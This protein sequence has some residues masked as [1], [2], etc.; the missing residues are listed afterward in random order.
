MSSQRNV[1]DQVGGRMWAE[2]LWIENSSHQHS[3]E[4]KYCHR[5]SGGWEEVAERVTVYGHSDHLR[6][7]VSCASSASTIRNRVDC[8][9]FVLLSAWAFQS[10]RKNFSAKINERVMPVLLPTIAGATRR[11]EEFFWINFDL[12]IDDVMASLVD[13]WRLNNNW[14]RTYEEHGGCAVQLKSIWMRL[15]HTSILRFHAN[16]EN[17][18]PDIRFG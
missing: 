14:R 12:V 4:Q 10:W 6:S 11:Q 3:A 2:Y 16:K 17:F 7:I 9:W 1:W 13:N 8:S 5:I 18:G 15:S